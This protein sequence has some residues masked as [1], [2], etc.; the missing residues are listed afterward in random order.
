MKS[1]LPGWYPPK[2]VEPKKKNTAGPEEKKDKEKKKKEGKKEPKKKELKSTSKT[3]SNE[4]S[5]EDP[6][7][8]PNKMDSSIQEV[9]E[10]KED[11][12]QK[13]QTSKEDPNS[14]MD[15]PL[16]LAPEELEEINLALETL[17]RQQSMISVK[18]DKEQKSVA[19]LSETVRENN[20]KISM[21]NAHAEGLTLQFTSELKEMRKERKTWP[22]RLEV[23]DG[24]QKVFFHRLQFGPFFFFFFLN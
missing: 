6:K 4:S 16:Q 11:H 15:E 12:E 13:D 3:E 5:Q 9:E 20:S 18:L 21:L 23:L 19:T 1:F 8:K 17:S 22:S 24:S 14:W 10:A 2:K 7:G